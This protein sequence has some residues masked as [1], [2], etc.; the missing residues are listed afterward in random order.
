M[1]ATTRN[2]LATRKHHALIPLDPLL[3]NA[4]KVGQAMERFVQVHI[5]LSN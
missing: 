4:K 2:I 5:S 3:A 1:N